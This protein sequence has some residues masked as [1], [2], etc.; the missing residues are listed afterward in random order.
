MAAKHIKDRLTATT[1]AKLSAPGMYNDGAGLYLRIAP[2]G[3]RHWL[4][5]YVL[6]GRQRY[7][8]LGS[9]SVFSL[10]EARVRAQ[11]AR[12]LKADGI[13]PI[14]T[15]TKQRADARA[16]GATLLTFKDAA[17]RY[18]KAH[19][20]GWRNPKHAAQ[21]TATL[22]AYA[23]PHVGSLDVR[24]VDT[25]LV[26]QILEPIWSTKPETAGRVRGRVEAVLDWATA[27]GHRQGENPARWKGHLDKLLPARG[28]VRKVKHHAALP[29]AEVGD[30]MIALRQQPGDAAEALDLLILTATRTSEIIAAPWPEIDLKAKVWTIGGERMKAGKEH[31]IPLSPPALAIL[32]AR[33]KARQALPEAE[34]SRWVFPGARL[35]HLSN[36][37]MLALLKRMKRDDVTP[38]GFRS[39]FRDWAAEQTAFPNHVVE[40]AL[41]HTIGDAVERSYRRGD[42]FEKRKRLMDAWAGFC[43]TPSA[44]GGNVAQMRKQG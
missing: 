23:Y 9:A 12:K 8:G 42:L 35:K 20:A 11:A 1:V 39:S 36:G 18:I 22:E 10:A 43:S 14:E 15:R 29:Y 30:F 6:D 37:A 5:R 13:D 32:E 7:M 21:W 4:Y 24:A 33:W 2:D 38:H 28:K 40:M 3:G 44:K 31:R 17:T 26:L 27:R 16:A 34:R 25:G 19:K 41:A